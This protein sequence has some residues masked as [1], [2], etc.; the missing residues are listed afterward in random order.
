VAVLTGTLTIDDGIK[1]HQLSLGE[2]M[3]HG[4]SFLA[5]GHHLVF[6]AAFTATGVVSYKVGA[7]SL[8]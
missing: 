8:C 1:V 7:W 5:D 6:Q 2:A 3:Q 4:Y